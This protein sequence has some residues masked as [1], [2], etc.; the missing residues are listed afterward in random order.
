MRLYAYEVHVSYYGWETDYP[1]LIMAHDEADAIDR[2]E[3]RFSQ[4]VCGK[5]HQGPL[6]WH[7]ITKKE[8]IV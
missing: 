3:Q 6:G 1:F 7:K 4:L 2:L 8:S 5:F